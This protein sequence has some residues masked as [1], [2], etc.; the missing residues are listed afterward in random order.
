M[1]E[2]TEGREKCENGGKKI[3]LITY[4]FTI[5]ISYETDRHESFLKGNKVYS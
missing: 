3:V 4:S 2:R 5:C 1:R